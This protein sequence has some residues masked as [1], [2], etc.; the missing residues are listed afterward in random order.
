M[1]AAV[2]V[3]ERA[4]Q[5]E[6]RRLR[7]RAERE[8]TTERRREARELARYWAEAADTPPSL[9]LSARSRQM[10]ELRAEGLSF[11]AIGIQFGLSRQ[12]VHQLIGTH[13][14]RLGARERR[15]LE[16]WYFLEAGRPYAARVLAD[17]SVQLRP[18]KPAHPLGR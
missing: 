4:Q 1:L 10:A 15:R 12:R 8:R 13:D 9:P 5:N 16:R 17:L 6:A 7:W 2:E 11:G 18:L 3:Q 14:R